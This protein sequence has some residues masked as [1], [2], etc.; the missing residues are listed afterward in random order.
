MIAPPLGSWLQAITGQWYPLY[1][2]SAAIHLFA[3]CFFFSCASDTPARTL[4]Y[5][6]KRESSARVDLQCTDM[7]LDIA[8]VDYRVVRAFRLDSTGKET[9]EKK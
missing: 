7:A 5:R 6:C 1:A 8:V 3:G 9:S 4:L 2:I